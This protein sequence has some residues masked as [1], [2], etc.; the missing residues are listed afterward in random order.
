MLIASLQERVFDQIPPDTSLP[1][2]SNVARDGNIFNITG[3]TQAGN[4]LFHSFREFSVPTDGTAS[5]NNA[6]D[7][8]N[9]ISR[10]TG[11]SVSINQTID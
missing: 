10:V 3:G 1:N 4:N 11:G 9:I 5:F 2:N 6:V 8:Q 7:I